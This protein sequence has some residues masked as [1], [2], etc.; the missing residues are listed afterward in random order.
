MFISMFFVLRNQFGILALVK[1]S[2][3]S[4]FTVYRSN[5]LVLHGFA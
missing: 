2:E 5:P 4:V 3:H 1:C